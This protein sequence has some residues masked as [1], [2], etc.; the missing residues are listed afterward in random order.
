MVRLQS[1][2]YIVLK[3]LLVLFVVAV[4][5]FKWFMMV[6]FWHFG[7]FFFVHPLLN[8]KQCRFTEWILMHQFVWF[9]VWRC[10]HC[11]R[12]VFSSKAYQRNFGI[13]NL[14]K[15]THTHTWMVWCFGLFWDIFHTDSDLFGHTENYRMQKWSTSCRTIAWFMAHLLVCFCF[16]HFM[17]SKFFEYFHSCKRSAQTT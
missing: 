1:D 9:S 14:G 13:E 8:E 2:K 3:T 10:W 5:H 15:H 12:R 4:C 11:W 7:E 6:F 16:S 17:S